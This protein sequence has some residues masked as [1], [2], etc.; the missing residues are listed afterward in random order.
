MFQFKKSVFSKSFFYKDL[1][2]SLVFLILFSNS[3]IAQRFTLKGSVTDSANV[4]VIAATVVLMEAKD[5]AL[6]GFIQTDDKGAFEFKEAKGNYV[7]QI[8]FVGF[9]TYQKAISL[10]KD[11]DVGNILLKTESK[12]LKELAVTAEAIPIKM[13]NDTIEY[14]AKVFKPQAGSMVE[15]LLKKLPGVEIGADG[16]IK[17]QGK[18]VKRILVD[19]EEFFGND[20]KM[21]TKNLPADIVDRVQVFDRRSEQAEFSGVDDGNEEK[22]INIKLRA[23]KKHGYFGNAEVGGGSDNRYNSRASINRFSKTTQ[24]SFIGLANNV[25]AEGFSIEDY[26]RFMGGMGRGDGGGTRISL[27]GNSPIPVGQGRQNGIIDTKAG[28]L[29]FNRRWSK[30]T[31]LSTNYFISSLG[32]ENEQLTNRQNFVRDGYFINRDTQNIDNQSLNHRLNATFRHQ[33]DSLQ[34]IRL[35]FNGNL[36]TADASQNVLKNLFKANNFATSRSLQDYV[37]EASQ[38]NWRSDVL[39]RRKIGRKG[40]TMSLGGNLGSGNN[41][42]NGFL[43]A[44]NDFYSPLQKR[45]IILQRQ[46]NNDQEQSYR[47]N[48]NYTHSLGKARLLQA[49]FSM[50]NTDNQTIKSFYDLKNEQDEDGVENPILSN[51]FKRGYVYRRGGL[52]YQR[53]TKKEKFST[54]IS[55]QQSQQEGTLRSETK[56][57][58]NRFVNILPN[59]RYRKEIKNANSVEFNYTT[60]VREPSAQDL[61]PIV[62]NADPLNIRQGNPNLKVAYLHNLNFNYT[63]FN[64]FEMRSFFTDFS[65]TYTANKIAYERSVDSAFRQIIQPINVKND[66]E[67]NCYTNFST[68]LRFIKSKINL[69]ANLSYNR[70]LQPINRQTLVAN[71][72]RSNIDIMLENRKKE[73][74]D[75]QIGG[76]IDF[77]TTIFAAQSSRNQQFIN[78]N[79]FVDALYKFNSRFSLQSVFR[80]NIYTA[81]NIGEQQTIPLWTANA[82]YYF[83]KNNKMKLKLSA[84]DLL[85]RNAGIN[86]NATANYIQEVR[87]TALGRYFM[88]TL[89]YN[90]SGF[91]AKESN[92]TDI[93]KGRR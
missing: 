61:Q 13:D 27:D 15:D 6:L 22:T 51:G 30:K 93:G 71:T 9:K 64:Q 24:L 69:N 21:A 48:G 40:S 77:N 34:N 91:G 82:T 42:S 59:L 45:D 74:L 56:P 4:P 18:D 23:D 44:Y 28:G 57:N 84:F 46:T 75:L 79:Y 88:L 50:Q 26:M 41:A 43:Y 11:S 2:K 92:A 36:S 38:Y 10:E 60:S 89:G 85:N 29:N 17:A 65:T 81:A 39:Y 67:A 87:N 37:S 25:N 66:F 3:L 19:G 70:A 32:Q 12:M 63:K 68:P 33:I 73:H 20:P 62:D 8:S 31:R 5:S 83:L 14:N 86:R 35:Q 55:L 54:G 49:G 80:Y 72:Y 76:G 90:L 78:Q 47:L 53:N 1:G 52:T 58:Q 7:L 16:S